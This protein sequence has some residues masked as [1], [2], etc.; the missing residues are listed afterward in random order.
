MP[1]GGRIISHDGDID[2]LVTGRLKPHAYPD[3]GESFLL[4][5]VTASADQI[6]FKNVTHEVMP[7]IARL[8]MITDG[9]FADINGNVLDKL[10]LVGEWTGILTFT[11]NKG[12]Y[13]PIESVLSNYKG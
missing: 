13:E 9:T 5:N 11:L 7:K 8:G 10:I 1:V 2:L 4:E 6:T 3:P 12:Q